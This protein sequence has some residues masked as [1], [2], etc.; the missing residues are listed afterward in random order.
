MNKTFI[1]GMVL[2]ALVVCVSSAAAQDTVTRDLPESAYPDAQITVNLTVGVET[3]AT[4]YTI[5]EV[6]PP[7]WNITSATYGGDHASETGHVKWVVTSAAADAI[8]SYTVDIPAD[9]A[10]GAHT[11]DGTYA[12]EGMTNEATILGDTTIAVDDKLPGLVSC[13]IDPTP[14]V[15][16]G[17]SIS[18][19]C[20][21]SEI[22]DYEIRIENATGYPVEII[23]NGT[24]MDPDLKWW[25]TTTDTP[26]EIYAVNV[27]MHNSTSGLSSYNNANTIRVASVVNDTTP[28]Y[29]AGHD[30]APDATGVPVG[31]NVI[32][33]IL[34]DD[35]GVNRSAIVMTVDATVVTPEITG[36][37]TDYTLI[38]DPPA[39]F[40]PD[41]LVN[42]TIGAS[43][44]AGNAMH[45]AYSFTAVNAETTTITI[46]DAI[47]STGGQFMPPIMG[48]GV[49]I[50]ATL[51]E[52]S[53]LK[54]AVMN[55][56][57]AMIYFFFVI[58]MVDLEALR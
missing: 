58:L 27:T 55:V 31:T 15:E 44:L 24:T 50:L 56:I 4:Y 47:A 57:P 11:F 40:D 48:A 45:D 41:Q 29:T 3:D 21:F 23:G 13:V 14:P 35:A 34:D 17:T 30:P 28:P 43:D 51:I 46:G 32:V 16:P 42:V 54:I 7:E 38:Y 37:P 25:N 9:A 39:D 36:T 52:V 10:A 20:L 8:Y 49:F 5:D 33:H 12:F 53:Y 19:D 26:E 18:I 2:I 22:V 1:F 6:V